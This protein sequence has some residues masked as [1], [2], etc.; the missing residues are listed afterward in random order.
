MKAAFSKGCQ[1]NISFRFEQYTA[2]KVLAIQGYKKKTTKNCMV[3]GNIAAWFVRGTA[4]EGTT[5]GTIHS[6]KSPHPKK[7]YTVLR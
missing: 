3:V 5:I 4:E 7:A 6:I 2:S 1:A